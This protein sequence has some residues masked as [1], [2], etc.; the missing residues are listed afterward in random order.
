MLEL[1]GRPKGQFNHFT[2]ETPHEKT[3]N[4]PTRKQMRRSAVLISAFFH[5]KDSGIPLA[6]LKSEISSVYYCDCTGWFVLDRV[7]NSK[8]WFSH[9]KAH[10]ILASAQ[11]VCQANAVCGVNLDT[12]CIDDPTTPECVNNYFCYNLAVVALNF[13]CETDNTGLY[14]VFFIVI[15]FD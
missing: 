2:F 1:V 9:A 7:G 6:P 5:Y 15:A 10:F 3:I 13:C 14:T 12:P 8:C 11:S 4:M